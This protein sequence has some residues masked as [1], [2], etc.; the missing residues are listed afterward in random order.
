MV[1]RRDRETAVRKLKIYLHL[2]KVS[3]GSTSTLGTAW[4]G[5]TEGTTPSGL[6]QTNFLR[7]EF[8]GLIWTSLPVVDA[9]CTET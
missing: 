4:I 8:L 3:L 6:A 7:R 5:D 9:E 2:L 1:D